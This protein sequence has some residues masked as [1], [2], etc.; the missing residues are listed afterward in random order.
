MWSHPRGLFSWEDICRGNQNG[1]VLIPDVPDSLRD[2]FVRNMSGQRIRDTKSTAGTRRRRRDTGGSGRGYAKDMWRSIL[3]VNSALNTESLSPWMK[4]TIRNHSLKVE[5]MISTISS[6]YASRAMQGFMRS[7]ETAGT[8]GDSRW[9][10]YTEGFPPGR[11]G[12]NPYTLKGVGTGVGSRV[13]F[14]G[15]KPTIKHPDR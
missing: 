15:F 7:A 3:S 6:L 8:T 4:Y 12:S 11:G 2:G 1:R 10:S 13:N 14:S 5:R 9:R